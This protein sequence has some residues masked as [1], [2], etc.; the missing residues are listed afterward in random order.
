M[1]T[2]TR[3]AKV[4]TSKAMT[5]PSLRRAFEE[6]NNYVTSSLSKVSQMEAVSGFQKKWKKI[7][8]KD[9]SKQAAADYLKFMGSK[10]QRGGGGFQPSEG[11]PLQYTM[12]EPAGAKEPSILPYV[13]QGFGF[14]NAD[15]LSAQCGKENITPNVPASIGMGGILSGGR[16]K[17]TRKN[18]KQQGGFGYGSTTPI[19]NGIL[20]NM[21]NAL[22]QFAQ[23]PFSPIHG[24]NGLG[25]QASTPG[26][27]Q[28]MQMQSKGYGTLPN[29]NFP[30][31]RPEIN[32]LRSAGKDATIYGAGISKSSLTY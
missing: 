11:A 5:I 25:M 26:A 19:S 2:K 21:P 23:R 18:K 30:S 8:G 15:S 13:N 32:T 10:R 29:G 16:R 17:G 24:P 27:F 3:K 9:I 7:F 20:A 1:V 28:V 31:P 12:G 22:A 6:I 4:V 14:A